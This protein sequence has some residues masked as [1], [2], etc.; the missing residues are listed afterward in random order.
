MFGGL[1]QPQ[2]GGTAGAEEVM[3][4]TANR[5]F[6]EDINVALSPP[7]WRGRLNE[8]SMLS[9]HKICDHVVLDKS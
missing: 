7:A 8:F 1:K 6:L 4:S 9:K 5:P 2:S 3:L